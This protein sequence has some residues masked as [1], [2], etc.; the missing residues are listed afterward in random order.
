MDCDAGEVIPH[1]REGNDGYRYYGF[2]LK[3]IS[4]NLLM[5]PDE[6]HG[7]VV[8]LVPLKRKLLQSSGASVW[9]S[10]VDL[11]ERSFRRGQYSL[12]KILC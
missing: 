7:R 9:V 1:S 4:L 2:L 11:F 6:S 5:P 12:Q 10:I 8:S 3:G